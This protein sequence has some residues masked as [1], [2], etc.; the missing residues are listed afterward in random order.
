M[1]PIR[2]FVCGDVMTG[3]GIDQI[4]QR[5]CEP[6]IHEPYMRSAVDYVLLAERASGPIPRAVAPSYIWGDALA[7][8]ERFS[9][10]ARVINLETAV[11][12]SAYWLPKG[13]NYRMSPENVSCLSAARIDCCVLANNHVLDWGTQ[14]LLDTIAT[15][16]AGGMLTV[17]AGRNRSVAE[18]AAVI[19]LSQKRRVLVFGVGALSS[20]VPAE[21]AATRNGPGVA[22]L[23]D[24]SAH[25]VRPIAR[26]IERVKQAGDFVILSIHWGSNWD[27]AISDTER[28]FAHA[29]IDEGAIDLIHGHSSHHPRAIEVHRGKLILWGCGDFINDYEGIAG[30]ERY[31]SDLGLMYLASVEPE[32]G[33]LVQL[34]LVPTQLRRLQVRRAAKPDAEWMCA[35]LHRESSG[36]GVNARIRPDGRIEI[37]W[38]AP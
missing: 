22:F 8:L 38:H 33:R 34:E 37:T 10:D 3:R 9:P 36:L 16:E 11:T 6:E 28:G 13:I 31:R 15:L 5:P 4:M 19:E 25:S 23:P 32:S 14:G 17:G 21:W 18:A 30:H 2:L 27:Y 12:R 20:G 35:V 1:N 7:E 29:L 24:F 26:R